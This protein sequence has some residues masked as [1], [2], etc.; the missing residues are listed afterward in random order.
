MSLD[1]HYD[2]SHFN[3]EPPPEHSDV[4]I[5]GAGMS[6]LYCAWR[7]L[8]QKPNRS[9]CIVEKIERAGGR[10]D[11][12]IVDFPDGSRVKEEQGGMRFTFDTMD[13]LMS[14]FLLLELD[15]KIVPFPMNNRLFFRGRA[16]NNAESA[17][18]D[19]AIWSDLY[20]LA[21]DE[22]GINPKSI[23]N[24]V[25]NRIRDANPQIE[26]PELRTPEFWQD[27]RLERQW[28]GTTLN[29]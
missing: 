26:W 22:Q 12:D 25:F 6:G 5:V 28:N 7:L 19:Y 18:N 20:N 17:E 14:L 2:A 29:N 8:Q 3:E 4:V 10:L 13:N 21:Q 27:F 9:V 11:S 1:T 15:S 24:I 23:I 16:F